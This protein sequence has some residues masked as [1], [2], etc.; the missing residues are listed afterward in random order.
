MEDRLG[1]EPQPAVVHGHVKAGADRFQAILDLG[2]GVELRVEHLFLAGLNFRRG[3]HEAQQVFVAVLAVQGGVGVAPLGI[4]NPGGHEIVLEHGDPAALLGEPQRLVLH[5]V[6]RQ[7]V[8]GLVLAPVRR[9][10][11]GGHGNE[12][13]G[14]FARVFAAVPF[15]LAVE[16]ALPGLAAVVADNMAD[17]DQVAAALEGIAFDDLHPA[18]LAQGEIHVEF[19]L[20]V[21]QAVAVLPGLPGGAAFGG[22][23]AVLADQPALRHI[24]P[25]G[26]VLQQNERLIRGVRVARV[27]RQGHANDVAA[28]GIDLQ[29][30]HIGIHFNALLGVTALGVRGRRLGLLLAGGFRHGALGAVRLRQRV[31]VIGGGGVVGQGLFL[32]HRRGLRGHIVPLPRLDHQVG[33]NGNTSDH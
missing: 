15:D 5:V 13:L 6:E 17:P 33:N 30:Q 19:F 24:G 21:L 12:A 25:A 3:G 22:V 23:G 11:V 14:A 10:Q 4:G 16:R 31:A 9:A 28:Q 2:T 32:G 20:A 18:A 26:V 8:V 1:Q 7:L 29:G 27:F